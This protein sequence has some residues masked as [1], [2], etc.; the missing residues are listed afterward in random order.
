MLSVVFYFLLCWQ[1]NIILQCVVMLNVVMLS[2]LMPSNTV[3]LVFL[4]KN[5]LQ[6]SLWQ[7]FALLWAGRVVMIHNNRAVLLYQWRHSSPIQIIRS[8]NPAQNRMPHLDHGPRHRSWW[9]RRPHS[10]LL[11]YRLNTDIGSCS[12]IPR[13]R[14]SHPPLWCSRQRFQESSMLTNSSARWTTSKSNWC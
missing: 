13:T 8:N 7:K 12:T 10:L 9:A 1:L 6:F 14:W 3:F 4:R 2:V 5:P 11:V